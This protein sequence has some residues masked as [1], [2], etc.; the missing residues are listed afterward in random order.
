MTEL[1]NQRWNGSWYNFEKYTYV[2][3]DNDKLLEYHFLGWDGVRE[4]WLNQYQEVS[5]YDNL[6][7]P[8]GRLSQVVQGN[9]NEF[10]ANIRN[11]TY[12]CNDN[13]YKTEEVTEYWN[14]SWDKTY[15]Y[16]YRYDS[17]GNMND[18]TDQYWDSYNQVWVNSQRSLLYY[19]EHITKI[20]MH[21]G[22][23]DQDM[24]VYPNP[25]RAAGTF[26]Y[27]AGK[28][29]MI[30]I[31]DAAGILIEALQDTDKDGRSEIL[32]DNHK[33][34]VYFYRLVSPERFTGVGW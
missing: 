27:P 6:G 1:L 25:V 5:T 7:N 10:W 28:I 29:A 12:L 23:A 3:N 31:Y 14:N 33:S 13:G 34:G 4:A 19:S 26:V 20:D 15:K 11:D 17:Y 21:N 32:F 24:L 22:T 18:S 2:Y 16:L 30:E 9:N 8:S